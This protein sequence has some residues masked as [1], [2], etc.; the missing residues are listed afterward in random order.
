MAWTASPETATSISVEEKIQNWQVSFLLFSTIL[1]NLDHIFWC[2][3]G[4]FGYFLKI[5]FSSAGEE[6]EQRNL[7]VINNNNN[8]SLSEAAADL[9]N[10]KRRSYIPQDYLSQVL[11]PTTSADIA[12][13]L[14]TSSRL[15]RKDFPKVIKIIMYIRFRSWTYVSAE[16]GRQALA[17][18]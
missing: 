6:H 13:A 9:N 7:N 2:F 17:I 14:A 10:L 1:E 11:D 4:H 3:L 8:G 12:A 18:C 16:V 15:K 5:I